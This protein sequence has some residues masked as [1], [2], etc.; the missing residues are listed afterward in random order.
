[1]FKPATSRWRLGRP[2]QAIAINKNLT[3]DSVVTRFRGKLKRLGQIGFFIQPAQG[4]AA[5]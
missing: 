4:Q 1:M 2:L 5:S 3:N